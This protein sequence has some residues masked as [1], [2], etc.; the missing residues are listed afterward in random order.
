MKHHWTQRLSSIC[1]MAMLL[2]AV[3][4]V[5]QPAKPRALDSSKA[6]TQYIHEAWQ[7]EDGL[8]QGSIAAIARSDDGYIWFG[9]QDGLVR[10]DG[11][12]FDIF[13]TNTAPSFRSN[14]IRTL[15]ND[16]NGAL[17][18]GTND[19]GLLKYRNGDFLS[20]SE[21]TLLGSARISALIESREGHLWVG[22][23]EKGVFRLAK[24]KMFPV[25]NLPSVKISALYEDPAGV[26]W[27]GTRDQGLFAYRRGQVSQYTQQNGLPEN[28]IVS[29][30]GGE[31][32]ILWI[33]TRT[34][35]L[36]LL[37]DEAFTVFNRRDGLPELE[38]TALYEDPSGVLWIG[39]RQGG[40]SRLI[41]QNRGNWSEPL[42]SQIESFS[43]IDGLSRNSVKSLFHDQEG[44]LWIGTDGGVDLF[45]EGKFTVYAKR[46]GLID[47]VMY[48]VHE[49]IDGTMWFSTENGVSSLKN[50]V[51]TNYTEN[52]G[53]ARNFVLSFAST[54]DGSVWMGTYGGGLS[55]FKN[56]KF[57]TYTLEDG[58]PENAVFALYADSR[59]DLWIGTGGGAARFRNESFQTFTTEDGLTSNEVTVFIEDHEGAMWIGTYNGG[60]NR[61]KDGTITSFTTK[62]NLSHDGILSLYEDQDDVLWIGTYGGGLN[63]VKNGIVTVFNTKDGLHNDKISHISEDNLGNLWMS[64]NQGPFRISKKELNDFAEG[65][66]TQVN[67]TAYGR[68][69]GLRNSELNGGIQPAGWRSRSG[70]LWL[71]TNEGIVSIDPDHIQTDPPPFVVIKNI[72]VDDEKMPIDKNF[73]LAPGRDQI[74]IQYAGISFGAPH[75]VQYQYKL[76]GEDEN[77]VEPGTRRAAYYNNLSPGEYTFYVRARNYDGIWSNESKAFSFTLKPFFYQTIWFYLLLFACSVALVF[78]GHRWRVA[79]L[80]INERELERI[81]E[82]RT[83]DLEKRTGDLLQALE[84]NKEIL[85]ITSHDLKNPL[86]GI[87]G[88]ADIL[89]EDLDDLSNLPAVQEGLENLHL[90]KSEAERMLRIVKELLDK[91]RTGEQ[92]ILHKERADFLGLVHDAVRW[93][94]QKAEQKNI[95]IELKDEGVMPIMVDSDAILRVADNLLSNAVKYSHPGSRVMVSLRS[96][97]NEGLFEVRDE[98]PG[99]SEEDLEKVFGKMQRL[100]AK[101]TGG[102]HSTGL[103]LFIVKQLVEEHDGTVGVESKLGEGAVFWVRLPLMSIETDRKRILMA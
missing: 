80:K 19:A 21:D 51:I 70:L 67:A 91:H 9:T 43:V 87:I 30:E 78:L 6:L 85:G 62:D 97:G 72:L 101:P 99:L 39:T 68:P 98:G 20:V 41:L 28:E 24:G 86:G 4:V 59:G 84:E 60:L 5:G 37:H 35:G 8:P 42:V 74:E 44:N 7:T 90:V 22:T 27:I 25:A 69:D 56:G 58:L 33:G 47:D 46:E 32:A 83:R 88:L 34:K 93:N 14:N 50:G 48:A 100:S 64:S 38:V 66:I 26:L 95:T 79:Q 36:A 81:V 71:P 29:L 2:I 16:R 17:W 75:K 18:I 10:F 52:E 12:E 65:Q 57:F 96:E 73:V 49:G 102:E 82:A 3:P 1:L 61:L 76:E 23:S 94:Q 31:G 15:L 55:R 63:R 54:A 53:L 77:W 92:N 40:L 103:G 89:I 45:R 13:D 11:V